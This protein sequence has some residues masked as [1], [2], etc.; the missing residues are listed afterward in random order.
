MINCWL[1]TS[2]KY[3]KGRNKA[4]KI[5]NTKIPTDIYKMAIFPVGIPYSLQKPK[6]SYCRDF[7][8]RAATLCVADLTERFLSIR[9]FYESVFLFTTHCS[10]PGAAIVFNALFL[11]EDSLF[12]PGGAERQWAARGENSG[13]VG[14][15]GLTP[16]RPDTSFPGANKSVTAEVRKVEVELAASL[17]W[18]CL[19]ATCEIVKKHRKTALSF[20]FSDTDKFGKYLVYF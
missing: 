18:H 19:T 3:Y 20:K 16:A 12:A 4:I 11:W 2:V 7:S 13:N 10:S 6:N 1:N 15:V 9:S 5:L 17:W 14:M 8:L